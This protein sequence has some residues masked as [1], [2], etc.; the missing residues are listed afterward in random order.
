[1]N[2]VKVWDFRIVAGLWVLMDFADFADF[3]CF[4]VFGL[5]IWCFRWIV[6]FF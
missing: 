3:W 6:F 4:C 5:T 2:L 1:M